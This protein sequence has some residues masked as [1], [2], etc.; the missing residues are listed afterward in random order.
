MLLV[1]TFS[2]RRT[3]KHNIIYQLNGKALYVQ[4]ETTGLKL[5]FQYI[6][7]TLQKYIVGILGESTTCKLF[8]DAKKVG[9]GGPFLLLM[10]TITSNK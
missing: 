4:F 9:F 2:Q 6:D 8:S 3:T 5:F 1:K 7:S 10:I